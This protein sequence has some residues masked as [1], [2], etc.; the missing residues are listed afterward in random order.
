MQDVE[1][2]KGDGIVIVV[3]IWTRKG[4]LP[5]SYSIF[6]PLRSSLAQCAIKA[7]SV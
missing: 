3:V 2:M 4:N 1:M 6:N 7:Q 5:L